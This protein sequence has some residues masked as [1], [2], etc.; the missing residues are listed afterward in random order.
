MKARRS[1]SAGWACPGAPSTSSAPDNDG[2]RAQP[3]GVD[4]RAF[5]RRE[6]LEA[7]ERARID[8]D[9]G[10]LELREHRPELAQVLGRDAG[11]ERHRHDAAEHAGPEQ[12]DRALVVGDVEQQLVA[13]DEAAALQRAEHADRALAQ[14]T[15]A[16]HPLLVLAFDECDLPILARRCRQDLVERVVSRHLRRVRAPF[17]GGP[18]RAPHDRLSASAYIVSCAFSAPRDVR[19]RSGHFRA[20]AFPVSRIRVAERPAAGATRADRPLAGAARPPPLAARQP[21]AARAAAPPRPS[22]HGAGHA[23]LP[24]ALAADAR[25]AA[26]LEPLALRRPHR[27]RGLDRRR[28]SASTSKRSATCRRATSRSISTPPSAP[29]PGA[30]PRRFYSVWT[31]K[32][33]VAKAAGTNGLPSLPAVDTT[34][35]PRRAAFAGQIWR[36]A[37]L[38]LGAGH[39]GHVATA[40][41]DAAVTF[42]HLPAEALL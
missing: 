26:A 23:A 1:G 8:A 39:V 24:A 13:G 10:A 7:L 5:A 9:P 11:R 34:A 4:R 42:E 15:K 17:S 21:A 31:R 37:P 22:G 19:L 36:T 41:L 38:A 3:G 33:A 14:A 2:A 12:L 18:D 27:R 32:E 28:R 29:G 40:D 6:G 16:Q 25:P 35:G 30:A 20:R